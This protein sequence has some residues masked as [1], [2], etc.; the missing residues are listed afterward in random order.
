MSMVVSIV[1]IPAIGDQQQPTEIH[2]Y[3]CC[4][5]KVNVW[6]GLLYDLIVGNFF[7]AESTVTGNIYQDLLEI[8][9]FPQ[10]DDLETVTGSKIIFMQD[11]APQFSLSV[12][13][14]LNGKFP[15]SWIGR[16]GPIPWPA[17]SP[18]LTPLD[19]FFWGYTKNIVYSKRIADISHLKR[20]IIAAIETVTPDVLFKTG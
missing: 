13:K 2:E 7:Y 16:D 8:Y 18:D 10:I 11:G 15:D 5:P 6:C 20:R 17:R 14:V 9:V 12:R 4:S 3:V 19:I 1:I